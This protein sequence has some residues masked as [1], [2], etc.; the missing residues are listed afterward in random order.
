MKNK[1]AN[2]N[3]LVNRPF[4]AVQQVD[5]DGQKDIGEDNIMVGVGTGILGLENPDATGN[6]Q[7]LGTPGSDTSDNG[8]D[9]LSQSTETSNGK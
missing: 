6:Q 9:S 5:P 2:E 8:S 4:T 7:E 3:R 1:I